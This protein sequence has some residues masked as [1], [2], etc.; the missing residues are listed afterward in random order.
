M[1]LWVLTGNEPGH[2]GHILL[3]FLLAFKKQ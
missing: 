2:P 1:G 3:A